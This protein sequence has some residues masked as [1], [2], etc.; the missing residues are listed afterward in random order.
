MWLKLGPTFGPYND[1]LI[2]WTGTSFLLSWGW[3]GFLINTLASAHFCWKGTLM[4]LIVFES[5][6][7]K[8]S[9]AILPHTSTGKF[10]G[11]R[12]TLPIARVQSLLQPGTCCLK[13]P[14]LT[15]LLFL[16]VPFRSFPHYTKTVPVQPCHCA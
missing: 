14:Q 6:L 3:Q 8:H 7:V 13:G 9:Q 16:A 4:R 2:S 11:E 10:R 15:P 5:F 1:R 12:F